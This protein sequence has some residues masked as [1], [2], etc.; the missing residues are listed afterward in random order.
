[1]KRVFDFTYHLYI[2]VVFPCC[3]TMENIKHISGKQFVNWSR[4]NSIWRDTIPALSSILFV[5]SINQLFCLSAVT[6]S[7]SLFFPTLM[8]MFKMNKGNLM[9]SW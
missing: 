5:N 7:G 9:I 4:K 3:G 6:I 8:E 1:M 2:R